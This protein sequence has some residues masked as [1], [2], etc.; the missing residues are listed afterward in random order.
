MACL[1]QAL[2]VDAMKKKGVLA[3]QWLKNYLEANQIEAY[4]P[5]VK[6]TK[7]LA[8]KNHRQ[9]TLTA[10]SFQEGTSKDSAQMR[11]F[12]LDKV[13]K[14][15]ASAI[16]N[17][18]K[19][20]IDLSTNPK[21]VEDKVSEIQG[22]LSNSVKELGY[23]RHLVVV[24]PAEER[25]RD[26]LTNLDPK[27]L[28]KKIENALQ[29]S[30]SHIKLDP[31]SDTELAQS[32]FRQVAS[33]DQGSRSRFLAENKLGLRA[34]EVG[35]NR[36]FTFFTQASRREPTQLLSIA[37]D[38]TTGELSRKPITANRQFQEMSSSKLEALA[39]SVAKIRPE[40]ET[41][42]Q[43]N[44]PKKTKNQGLEL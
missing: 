41:H 14:I 8:Y 21:G 38:K 23:D 31:V 26:R 22:N 36:L 10:L 13:F 3:E 25:H 7:N 44:Q 27:F 9:K 15:D 43:T 28:I 35:K 5:P 20:A 30:A 19:V 42:Q 32:F 18:Q 39:S 34:T 6:Q 24:V 29:N 33:L 4:A 12:Y 37:Q 40:I 2:K 1:Q 17:G 11:D 16:I